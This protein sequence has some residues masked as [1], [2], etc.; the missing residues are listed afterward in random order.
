MHGRG[1][2]KL[3]RLEFNYA[4]VKVAWAWCLPSTL[5]A[6]LLADLIYLLKLC[7][8]AKGHPP[9]VYT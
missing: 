6:R 9:K 5:T 2:T 8:F 4:F 1:L 3:A 7:K